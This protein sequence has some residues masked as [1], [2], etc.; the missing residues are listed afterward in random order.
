[1]AALIRPLPAAWCALLVASLLTAAL[2]TAQW[3][4]T[5]RRNALSADPAALSVD[6]ETPPSL[7]FAKAWW[8][9]RAGRWQ[10]AQQL[11]HGL[12][13]R[14]EGTLRQRAFYNL[15]SLYLEQAAALWNSRG[16]LEYGAVLTLVELAKDNLQQAL[17]LNP[18][19]RDARFNLEYAYRITPPPKEKPKADFKGSKASIFATLPGIPGGAP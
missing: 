13:G 14:S 10:D 17:R 8:L 9:A 15:G 7:A 12:A 3:L 1:M 18:D 5:A 16:V 2:A 19:D 4:M 6:A 11:Y